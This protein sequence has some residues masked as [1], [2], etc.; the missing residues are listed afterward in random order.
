MKRYGKNNI[1]G[2]KIYYSNKK[3]RLWYAGGYYNSFLGAQNIPYFC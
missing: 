3:D 2:P 1:Y